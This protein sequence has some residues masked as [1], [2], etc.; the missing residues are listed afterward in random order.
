MSS[1]ALSP[2][3]D[4]LNVASLP[5][6]EY[7]RGRHERPFNGLRGHEAVAFLQRFHNGESIDIDGQTLSVNDVSPEVEIGPPVAF[8][9]GYYADGDSLRQMMY[10]ICLSG[11]RVLCYN[12]YHGIEP[13]QEFRAK[14]A[15]K[16]RELE[17]RDPSAN[18]EPQ[19][20]K[21]AALIEMLDRKGVPRADI[22]GHSEGAIVGTIASYLRPD[23]FGTK[24]FLC[25]AGLVGEKS[26][27]TI[28]MRKALDDLTVLQQRVERTVSTI[29]H[30]AR[31]ALQCVLPN[32]T[33]D[34]SK[35]PPIIFRQISPRLGEHIESDLTPGQFIEARGSIMS[36]SKWVD[37]Q[38]NYYPRL[39]KEYKY[40]ADDAKLQAELESLVDRRLERW[41]P[42]LEKGS[43]VI[44]ACDRDQ[45]FPP[46]EVGQYAAQ[47]G[48]ENIDVLHDATHN[49]HHF[50]PDKVTAFI[51]KAL[52]IRKKPS[53]QN[54]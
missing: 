23:L 8:V 7:V 31:T 43:V 15:D 33:L 4:S 46:A 5:A 19:L 17:E 13:S 32:G 50:Q 37:S 53:N 26:L 41:L 40:N 14:Y 1:S 11:R 25:P 24:A 52:R 2:S 38:L 39:G 36:W 29:T 21:A 27:A 49:A 20:R 54:E 9:S 34:H 42:L 3:E 47:A 44:G 35:T 16:I 45:L 48:I 28:K 6:V 10:D 51:K 18:I 22:F 12:S 30:G